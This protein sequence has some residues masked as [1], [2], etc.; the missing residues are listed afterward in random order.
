MNPTGGAVGITANKK[1]RF[2]SFYSAEGENYDSRGADGIDGVVGGAI[3]G[4]S[5]GT[6]IV[7]SPWRGDF[8]GHL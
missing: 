6:S 5:V 4:T 7:V 2:L 1:I 8:L 3:V